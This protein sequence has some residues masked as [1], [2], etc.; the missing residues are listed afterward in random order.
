MRGGPVYIAGLSRSGKTL[1]GSVLGSHSRI[2]IPPAGSNMW[3]YFHGQFG[4]LAVDANLERAVSALLRYRHVAALEPDAE[5]I[6]AEAALGPRTYGHLFGLLLRH[7]AE[8]RGKPRWGEHTGL[9]EIHAE[10]VFADFPEA[11]IIH[12]VRDPRDRYATT[13]RLYPQGRGG[14]GGATAWWTYSTGLGERH[15]RRHASRYR[16]VRYEDLASAPEQ[17]VR[18]ICD[19]IGEAFEPAMLE[20]GEA[21]AYAEMLRRGRAPDA[22]SGLI[23]A[24]H[25]GIYRDAIEEE[26]VAFIEVHAGPLM[27]RRGY[28]LHHPRPSGRARLRHAL[29]V[30][31][32]R[33]ARLVAAAAVAR[34]QA[35]SPWVARRTI[36]AKVL[37]GEG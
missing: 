12:I 36:A 15:A 17:T 2:A 35:R 30:D 21:P 16:I 28:R 31:P 25:V 6:R 3:A 7:Y 13:R 20:M 29:L 37:R 18:A 9:L 22:T 11:R 24:H 33:T 4:D 32:A 14:V 5:R 23:A 34:L 26:D 8:A 27:E 19:F 10:R 1:L